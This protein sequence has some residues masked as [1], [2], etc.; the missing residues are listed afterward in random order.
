MLKIGLAVDTNATMLALF[1]LR[2]LMR[3]LLDLQH[4]DFYLY[5]LCFVPFPAI[6]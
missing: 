4:E 5:Y 3:L 2:V 6:T 1:L